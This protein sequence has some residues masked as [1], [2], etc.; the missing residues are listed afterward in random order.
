MLDLAADLA[1][2]FDDDDAVQTRPV[3]ALGQPLDVVD[4]G[5]GP[6]L[7]AAMITIDGLVL[8]GGR[9]AEAVG[10]LLG[11]EERDIVTQGAL[12]AFQGQ[13]VIGLLVDDLAGDIALAAHGIDGDRWPL[14]WPACRAASG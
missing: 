8:A 13:D 4:H 3:M 9:V 1:G 11:H 6:G 5:R 10:G 14:R 7:D 2:A 12:I